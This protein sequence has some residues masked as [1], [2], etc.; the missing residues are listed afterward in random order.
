LADQK[1]ELEIV[2]DDGSIKKAFGTI[3][4]EAAE[5]TKEVSD[6]FSKSTSVF[7]K[8]RVA[9]YKEEER[10]RIAAAQALN[11]YNT[12]LQDS[13]QKSAKESAMVFQREFDK[14]PLDIFNLK[15]LGS[16]A[17]GLFIF[18]Q[19]SDK[20]TQLVKGFLDL[21]LA[22]EKAAVSEAQFAAFT[23][24]AG[25]ATE[26]LKESIFRAT[27]GL[28]END[29]ALG[30][31][32]QAII[33]LGQ[34]AQR[35]PEIFEL[36]RKAAAAGF[37]DIASNAEL[38]TQAIQTGNA[39]QLRALGLTVDLTKAQNEFAKSIGLTAA[40][41]TDEQKAF[42][43]SNTILA[44]AEKRFG[45]VD[46]SIRTT[47]DALS[48]FKVAS[49]EAFE[50]FAVGF[51]KAFGGIIRGVLNT[52]TEGLNGNG[53][54]L[55][56][57]SVNAANLGSEI[58]KTE[59]KLKKFN[60]LLA[61]AKTETQ[62]NFY[63]RQITETNA[64]LD[65][66]K[67][68]RE[69]INVLDTEQANRIKSFPQ[70]QLEMEMR[71]KNEEQKRQAYELEIQRETNLTSFKNQMVQQELSARQQ[72]AQLEFNDDENRLIQRQLYEQQLVMIAEQGNQ[73]RLAIETNF[74][75]A[76]GY[77]QEQRDALEIQR[78]N[79]TNAQL[80]AA[81]E[82]YT[83]QSSYDFE[84]F[85]I[86]SSRTWSQLGALAKQTF[87]MGIGGAFAEMGQA[88]AKGENSLAA[89]GKAMLG[90]LGDIAI[91]IGTFLF[92]AGLGYSFIPGFQAAAGSV[93]LGLAL[94]AFGGFLKGLSGG[95]G[96]TGAATTGG[97]GVASANE[98]GGFNAAQPLP[99]TEMMARPSTVVNFTV[100]GDIL[101]S[102]STQSRIV[103]LLNDAIDTKGAV[104][105][106]MA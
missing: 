94:I 85:L 88:L 72:S 97:G 61:T 24:D 60:E 65:E 43:N 11:K 33:R 51:D 49:F 66:L 82:T 93:P 1:I 41:L 14:N 28:I 6:I 5:V 25:I 99:T 22:A 84:K 102:D 91:Q 95:G 74:S 105:R 68:R 39:R 62:F 7:E 96:A 19:V 64:L 73:Q 86:K 36:S 34:S 63:N 106:G 17:A 52:L 50:R 21:S 58:E 103:Q 76:K 54:A 15:V 30:I 59:S 98:P 8:D 47:S 83:Y 40:Q 79:S 26:S 48:R 100:Q 38:L 42:V 23:R 29:Q 101:D 78:V 56:A 53:A 37:N 44:E 77:T 9:F 13:I 18:N 12:S 89:F 81:Q 16:F 4:K 55:K 27:D 80:L 92:T 45:K 10:R 67:K 90:T 87:V 57:N 20:V 32:N 3:R 71:N 31:A 70:F 69:A 46:A 75:N 104:V 2:L 35:L